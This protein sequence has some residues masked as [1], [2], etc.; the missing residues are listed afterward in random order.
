[1]TLTCRF[2]KLSGAVGRGTPEE[3]T[4][5]DFWNYIQN[6]RMKLPCTPEQEKMSWNT[7]PGFPMTQPKCALNGKTALPFADR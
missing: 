2:L 7:T 5:L 4:E 6:A 3:G 1:M